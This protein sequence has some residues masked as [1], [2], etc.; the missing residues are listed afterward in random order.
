MNATNKILLIA[1]S[2]GGLALS[3]CSG[4]EASADRNDDGTIVADGT[5]DAFSLQVGDC[6]D[7]DPSLAEDDLI[8]SVGAVPCDTPHDNEVFALVTAGPVTGPYPGDD[9]IFDDNIAA[10]ENAFAR[11]VGIDYVDS[12][13]GMGPLLVP[14]PETWATGDREIVCGLYNADGTK[15][16]ESM[17]DAGERVRL[18]G[19]AAPEPTVTASDSGPVGDADAEVAA[20][21]AD[22][23]ALA[24][25]YTAVLADP[26]SGDAAALVARSQELTTSASDLLTAH[27]DAAA[28]V[29]AC[30]ETLN[31]ALS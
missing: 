6:F 20:F 14:S 4:S 1:A 13:L 10:C 30:I 2:L 5:V 26:S 9:A 19:G 27:P 17:K 8:A 31:A 29:T 18:E 24:E 25:E 23:D 7:D 21:C 22:V 11:Y 16:T 12:F 15:L 3:A 28:T